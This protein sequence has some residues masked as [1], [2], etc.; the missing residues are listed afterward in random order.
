[1]TIANHVTVKIGGDGNVKLKNLSGG[2][3]DLAAD[4]AGWYAAGA[5]TAATL[6]F[7]PDVTYCLSGITGTPPSEQPVVA[8]SDPVIEHNALTLMQTV[9]SV[10]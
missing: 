2:K 6:T 10:I 8:P 5:A 4:V 9:L 7:W 1:M 3:V